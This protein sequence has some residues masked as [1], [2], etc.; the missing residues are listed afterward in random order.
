M[1]QHRQVNGSLHPTAVRLIVGHYAQ[2]AELGQLAPHDLRRTH[3]K[4]ARQGGASLEVVS[5][6]LGHASV[7][8][9]QRYLG[10]C[11]SADAGSYFDLSIEDVKGE[12]ST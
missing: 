11:E 8:T 5:A 10:T 9:T 4:L 2:L 7:S 6:S 3:A 1:S 12:Q